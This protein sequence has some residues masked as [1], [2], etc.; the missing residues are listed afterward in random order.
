MK[1]RTLIL[2]ALGL[3]A[4]SAGAYFL[5]RKQINSAFLQSGLSLHEYLEQLEVENKTVNEALINDDA[6]KDAILSPGSGVKPF[7][8]QPSSI[9]VP[10]HFTYDYFKSIAQKNK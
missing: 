2:A 5:F 1:I 3:G 7:L 9:E 6:L 4:L 10:Q 8:D